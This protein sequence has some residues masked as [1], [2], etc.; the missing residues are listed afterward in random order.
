MELINDRV[1]AYKLAKEIDP[2]DLKEV[3]GGSVRGTAGP[4][5]NIG[6]MYGNV[7][8]TLDW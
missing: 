8:V 7:D 2:Q 6:N 3:S 4:T 1:L 5:G